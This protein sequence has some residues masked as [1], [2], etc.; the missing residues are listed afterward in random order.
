M[1]FARIPDYFE[2]RCKKCGSTD[3]SFSVE[4]CGECGDSINAECNV[5]LNKYSY[6]DFIEIEDED[7]DEE[8]NM[9]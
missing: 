9:K 8:K 2:V 5:C 4:E 7:E 6:H 1:R 3:V